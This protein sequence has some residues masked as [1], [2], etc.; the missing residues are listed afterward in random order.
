MTKVVIDNMLEKMNKSV[1]VYRKE[2]SSM[3]AGRANPQL[4]DRIT[5]EYYGSQ[6]PINQVANISIPE[7]RI[8]QIAPWEQSMLKVIEKAIQKSDLGINPSNDGKIIRLLLPEL[9]QER[10]K[11]LVKQTRKMAEDCKVAIRSI[12]RDANDQIK[13]MKKDNTITEDE[14]KSAEEKI[15]KTTDKIVKEVDAI[16]AEKEK[17][18]MDV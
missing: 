1:A 11:E 2:L 13:K 14:Q 3:R 10:R 8:I 7:P 15:Q 9:T 6:M 16:T 17:E 18:L 4:L 12:R 5:V